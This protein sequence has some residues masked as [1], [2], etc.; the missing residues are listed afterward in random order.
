MILSVSDLVEFLERRKLFPNQASPI[1]TQRNQEMANET[2]ISDGC[3]NF[4]TTSP[5]DII[6]DNESGCE[7]KK[8][9]KFKYWS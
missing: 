6:C 4:K 8:A 2:G 3:E 5:I 7:P 9:T 1:K